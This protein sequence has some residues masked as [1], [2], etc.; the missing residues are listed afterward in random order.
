M[1][2]CPACQ[3]ANPAQ[4]RF[5]GQ[6]GQALTAVERPAAMVQRHLTV[7]FTDLVGSTAISAQ[8]DPEDL[9]AVLAAYYRCCEELIRQGGGEVGE[10]LGDGLVC[11]FGY[12]LAQEDAA[13]RAVRAALEVAQALP[14]LELPQ[15]FTLHT[16]IGIA[17][18]LVVVDR[19]VDPHSGVSK[20]RVVGETANLAA[21]LQGLA[22]VDGVVLSDAT[23]RIVGELFEYQDLGRHAVKGFEAPVQAW[24]VV[25]AS[26]AENRFEA[27]IRA[28]PMPLIGRAREIATLDGIWTAARA[29]HGRAVLIVGEPGI[30]KSRLARAVFD[31][32]AG[33]DCRVVRYYSSPSLA[34]TELHPMIQGMMRAA[35]IS[36]DDPPAR[37]LP[38]LRSFLASATPDPPPERLALI[39]ALL[40]ISSPE[41]APLAMSPQRLRA[42]TVE[43]LMANLRDF[44]RDQP[45][46]VLWEDVH[47]ADPTSL[48]LLRL[49]A[50]EI[51]TLPVL[52]LM[53]CRPDAVPAGLDPPA[54]V[55]LRLERLDRD[56]STMMIDRVV[57]GRALPG[58]VLA[59]IV[60]NTDGVPLFIEELTRSL[61]D[62][63]TV[64]AREDRYE[65]AHPQA[66]VRIPVTLMDSL[67]ARLDRLGPA[68]EVAQVG[69]VIG[70]RFGRDML[71]LILGTSDGELEPLL[72][73]LLD[74]ELVFPGD[75]GEHATYTF[76]HA[77]VQEA[78]YQTI[79]KSRRRSLHA[80]VA[81]V[82]E[83]HF[84]ARCQTAPEAVARHLSAA[85]ESERAASYWQRA[86]LLALSRAALSE[87][88]AH[89]EAGLRDTARRRPSRERDLAEMELL[90]NLGATQMNARGFASAELE[91]AY[92]AAY[93][94]CSKVGE[95][96][97]QMVS[98]LWGL[99]N[100]HLI[101]GD[102]PTASEIAERMIRLARNTA[103]P[104]LEL[105]ALTARGATRFY[106]GDF[107]G[108]L[109]HVRRVRAGYDF[110]RHRPFAVTY[111]YDLLIQEILFEAHVAWMLGE[112]ARAARIVEEADAHAA[113]L[114]LPLMA[115][116]LLIWGGAGLLYRREVPPA[117]E[118]IERGIALAD[119]QGF[120]F[121]SACGRTWRGV[122]LIEAGGLDQGLAALRDGLAAYTA[123]GAGVGVPYFKARLGHAAAQRGG[124][125]EALRLLG[126][127]LDQVEVF[128]EGCW[129]A[130]IL[131]LK[132]LVL[133][134]EPEPDPAAA[135]EALEQSLRVAEAQAAPAWRLRTLTT[136][137]Q[138]RPEDRAPP[139]QLAATLAEF[140]EGLDLPD[141]QEARAALA[142]ASS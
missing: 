80:R 83:D 39:A 122:A 106:S 50:G 81:Q 95:S 33:P 4:M 138:L 99:L 113:R 100:Y 114:G 140:R 34:N 12:P 139:A 54:V 135:G 126:E 105:I 69:A 123:I 23:R 32:A 47:W 93:R 111:G 9:H 82:L 40:G 14:R 74:A 129:H 26:S 136:W 57:G 72:R 38:K 70:R 79:L 87:A 3:F 110:E 137:C 62:T 52:L 89:F 104:D 86:G 117:L 30:G 119:A 130:E 17:T 109:E 115:P 21:R 37:A 11:Y 36:A 1:T 22:P 76:K 16:R 51:A 55:Q 125:P 142:R 61:I 107:R 43:A 75:D 41:L 85:G 20:P 112:A 27:R 108:L 18:G 65:L 25:G 15:R 66:G 141:L 103:D 77:L 73:R 63:G 118:R 44:A 101:V 19:V 13:E 58:G 127:A 2:V 96:A 92:N 45:M 42:K 68:R 53:T 60:A 124:K 94:L 98:V 10:Y 64:V 84:P 134:G 97:P 31:S 8:L 71:R 56:S 28:L 133:A 5:C 88:V 91:A 131:R 35:G 6:C 7:L 116:Y 24:R 90:A 59:Q 29:G 78:A 67:E 49:A 102:M 120:G 121:W 132:A 46:L 128:N 48:E